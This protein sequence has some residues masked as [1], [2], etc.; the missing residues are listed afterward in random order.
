MIRVRHLPLPAGLIVVVRRDSDGGLQVVVSDALAADRQRSAVRLALRS[1]GRTRWRAVLLP[2]PAGLL[3]DAVR[4]SIMPITRAVRA[5]AIASSAAAL[6]LAAGAAALIVGLPQ[7]R[8]PTMAGQ[9]P[10][11]SQVHAPAAGR[12]PIARRPGHHPVRPPGA[13][14]VARP[15]ASTPRGPVTATSAPQSAAPS[16]SQPAPGNPSKS[17]VPLPS[18]TPSPTQTAAPSPSPSPPPSGRG[19]C[20]VILGIWVCL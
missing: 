5:H 11:R 4:R 9:N 3:L 17:A 19:A 8:G 2:L 15:S 20:L 10:G 13:I 6:V 12:T 18:A 7:H 14:A 16:A 1:M